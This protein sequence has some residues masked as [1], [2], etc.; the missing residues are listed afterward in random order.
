MKLSQMNIG[1]VG[2]IES[3]K[4]Q[5][6]YKNRLTILGL[7]Q[8]VKFTIVRKAIF[9]GP[10]QIKLRDFYLAISKNIADKIIVK[11]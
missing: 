6:D 5:Q 4:T 11:I 2:V 9:N 7:T 1:Q 8:G 3:I 10:I